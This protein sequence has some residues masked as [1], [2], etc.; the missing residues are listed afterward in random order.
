M[1]VPSLLAEGMEAL[2]HFL[3]DTYQ[4]E[5]NSFSGDI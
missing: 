4:E 2:I 5:R 3:V 1:S